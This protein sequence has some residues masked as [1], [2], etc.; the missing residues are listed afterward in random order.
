MRLF[1]SRQVR[2]QV[3]FAPQ[4]IWG[5]ERK[6]GSGK[7]YGVSA[8]VEALLLTNARTGEPLGLW[9]ADEAKAKKK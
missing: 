5:L 2:L 1:S 9:F 3:I 7:Q 4:S 6:Q 8:R